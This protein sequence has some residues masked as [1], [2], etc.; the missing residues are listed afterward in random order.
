MQVDNW[1]F[2]C[3]L[4]STAC[5]VLVEPLEGVIGFANV[6]FLLLQFKDVNV[7]HD[8]LKM[9]LHSNPSSESE[10]PEIAVWLKCE[11]LMRA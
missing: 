9:F 1:V 3:P 11:L 5:S 10:V 6:V 4:C 8:L 7:D 2:F